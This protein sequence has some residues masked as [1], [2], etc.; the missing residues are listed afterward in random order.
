MAKKLLAAIAV[1]ALLF[2]GC[3]GKETE[4]ENIDYGYFEGYYSVLA[5]EVRTDAGIVTEQ[6][7][8]LC[9]D[10]ELQDP[11]G[12]KDVYFNG[13][14]GELTKYTVTLGKDKTE[15]VV[16]YVKGDTSSAYSEAY[17]SDSEKLEKLVWKNDYT[18]ADGNAMTESGEETYYSDGVTKKTFKD[19][20]YRGEE[21]VDS[22]YEEY[23][24]HGTLIS[25]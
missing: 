7:Y 23:D 4:S 20:T 1:I 18:D 16:E 17:Y 22:K 11:V 9:T 24:E 25:G 14:T 13:E 19:E 2:C 6:M 3:A 10:E 5:Y 15:L 12:R 21:L 8:L